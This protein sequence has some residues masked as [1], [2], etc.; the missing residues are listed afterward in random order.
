[1]LLS[2]SA[3][4]HLVQ[5]R[6]LGTRLGSD[7][8]PLQIV[9]SLSPKP[10]P[11][12]STDQQQ[13]ASLHQIIPSSKDREI[14][15]LRY[16]TAMADPAAVLNAAVTRTVISTA[17]GAGYSRCVMLPSPGQSLPT[18]KVYNRHKVWHDAECKRL[19]QQFRE[20]KGDPQLD[21][22]H[23]AIL[24]QY[25]KRVKQLVRQC[26]VEAALERA[27]QLIGIVFGAVQ[28]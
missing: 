19:Q 10:A 21:T 15:Q 7:H 12:S 23:R 11:S 8:L 6:V 3:L 18:L 16:I 2:P 13:Q 24:Q 28:T 27:R 9:L 25:K 20:L 22:E 1:M 4:H 26:R 5:H 17:I 14:V